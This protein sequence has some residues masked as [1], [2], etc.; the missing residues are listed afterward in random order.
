M[1]YFTSFKES[2]DFIDMNLVK[3]RQEIDNRFTINSLTG[4]SEV[5]ALGKPYHKLGTNHLVMDANTASWA[6]LDD[7]EHDLYSKLNGLTLSTLCNLSNTRE[8]KKIEKF[9]LRLFDRGLV[10]I[11]GIRPFHED[12]YKRFVPFKDSLSLELLI[13]Q[14]CNFRCSYC[15]ANATPIHSI[16]PFD[17]ARIAIYNAFKLPYSFIAIEISGGE[18]LLHFPLVR[19]I[20]NFILALST[21]TEKEVMISIVADAALITQEI[22]EFFKGKN[23]KIIIRLDGPVSINY[24]SRPAVKGRDYFDIIMDSIALL[25]K[26]DIEFGC[27]I[28]LNRHYAAYDEEMITFLEDLRSSMVKIEYCTCVG[29]NNIAPQSDLYLDFMKRACDSIIMN[30]RKII[31]FHLNQLLNRLITRYRD[32]RCMRINCNAGKSYFVVNPAGDVFPCALTTSLGEF[33]IENLLENRVNPFT[34]Y[35]AFIESYNSRRM[36][37]IQK[38]HH[39][40]WRNHCISNCTLMNY[41]DGLV[42]SE[43]QQ[44]DPKCTF[45]SGIFQHVLNLLSNNPQKFAQ[46]L[47]SPFF[48]Y[49]PAE[50]VNDRIL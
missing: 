7:S 21:I 1:L 14:E 28:T 13:T 49:G 5:L 35:I 26:Y 24:L 2:S 50:V 37:N 42:M 19:K 23:V 6:L 47:A 15:A 31:E 29:K 8:P 43:F 40:C 3:D 30:G 22:L 46:Y 20:V 36:S 10:Q 39:C 32:Y 16:M 17:I 45:Y 41:R 27:I 38:C 44:A 11:A 9:I 12:L 33:K 18:P 25:H 34:K 48:T 4:E